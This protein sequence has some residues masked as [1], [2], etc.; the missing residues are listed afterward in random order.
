TEFFSRITRY[1]TSEQQLIHRAVDWAEDLHKEQKRAS[2]EPYIIHPIQVAAILAQL[3][4]D[5]PTV[6]AGILHDVLED[7]S[8]SATDMEKLFGPEVVSLV[9]GVTKIHILHAKTKS[10]Q[11]A[12]TIRKM[13]FAMIKDL[14][15]IMI[16]LAD[17]VHNMTTL[18]HLGDDKVRRIAQECL[19]IYAPLADRL[20]MSDLK[21]YLEDMSLKHLDKAAYYQIKD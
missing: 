6:I 16:K 14:R 12:E 20:G 13:F 4:M 1:T 9:D 11:E 7:T 19:D 21:N 18:Q 15:V 5:A 17:K 8:A 3:K 2:G 10:V